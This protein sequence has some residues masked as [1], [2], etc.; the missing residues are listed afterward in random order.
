VPRLEA[1]PKIGLCR[2]QFWE[3]TSP[4]TKHAVEDAAKRLTA[5]G[6]SMRDVSL[7]TGFEALSEARS[8]VNPVERS[9]ALAHEWNTDRALI[10]PGL[11]RQI[12]E[13]MK[14]PYARY[15][16][17]LKHI[18]ACR[19]QVTDVFGDADVLLAPCVAGEAPKGLDTTGDPKFQE[20]WTALHV[21][22]LTLPT[23]KGP[24]GL[25]V[26]IQLVGRLYDDERLIAVARWV[27]ERLGCA[28]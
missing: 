5:A 15:L 14:I 13:G 22:T 10:S 17:S 2:T 20:F 8:I 9:R 11:S 25:P 21:P 28:S 26:G 1:I 19:D 23:H 27:F 18:A 7:P 6:A 16:Q 3:A 4:E 24:N 12:E